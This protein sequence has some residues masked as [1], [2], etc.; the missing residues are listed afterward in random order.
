LAVKPGTEDLEQRLRRALEQRAR[1]L[2]VDPPV[3]T[4][5]LVGPARPVR[6]RRLSWLPAAAVSTALNAAVAIAVVAWRS[7][8]RAAVRR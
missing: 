4:G 3:W 1:E 6:R 5:P 7:W 8:W 2:Q